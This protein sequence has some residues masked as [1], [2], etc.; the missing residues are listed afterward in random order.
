MLLL[1]FITIALSITQLLVT[2]GVI[3]TPNIRTRRIVTGVLS[4]V[5]TILYVVLG[6][7]FVAGMWL[8]VGIGDTIK[9]IREK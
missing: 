2:M 7:H 8:M 6:N 3:P 4:G 9:L 1:E 5:L